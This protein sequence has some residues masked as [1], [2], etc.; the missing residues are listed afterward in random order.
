V[1]LPLNNGHHFAVKWVNTDPGVSGT[2]SQ[3]MAAYIDDITF[4]AE[5]PTPGDIAM[6]NLPGQQPKDSQECKSCR[7]LCDG[8]LLGR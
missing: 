6:S 1:T 2:H 3:C 7:S 8:L 4:P 5:P